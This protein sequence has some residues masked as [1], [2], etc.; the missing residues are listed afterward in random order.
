M[1]TSSRKKLLVASAH[2]M[3]Q[4]KQLDG[5][6]DQ[7]DIVLASSEEEI[8]QEAQSTDAVLLWGLEG[9]G[10]LLD[11]ILGVAP[12]LRWVHAKSAG[13][14]PL[15]TQKLR[16][17]DVILT[18]ARGVYS[19][20][21]AEFAI[22]GMLYFAKDIPR[23]LGNKERHCWEKFEVEELFGRTLSVFGYGSIGKA[24]A[25]KAKAF[26]MHVLA[27]RRDPSKSEG[28][29]LVD[30]VFSYSEKD[31]FFA[32]ADYLAIAAPETAE[33]KGAIGSSEFALMKETAV[34][35]NV[36]RGSVIREDELVTALQSGRI[37]G[38]AL[39]VFASEPLPEQSPLWEL[40]NV[41]LS[42]HTADKTATALD[43]TMELFV[44]NLRRFLGDQE[45]LNICNTN[46][47]Y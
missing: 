1:S 25:K 31:R 41:L 9:D 37:R 3:P 16:E 24:I 39:D 30:E 15:I 32:E 13:V 11:Q 35:I 47:G 10:A 17:S 33:T 43:E 46:L 45:L 2:A 19:R 26:E 18:N 5:V 36:G 27:Y 20:S 23:L 21:L 4:L 22:T 34:I 42:P 8:L 7:L 44:E 28:D 12:Q 29:P 6:A 40:P 14:A 38:A